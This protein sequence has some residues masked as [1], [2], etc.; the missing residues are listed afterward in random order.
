MLHA[1]VQNCE[2]QTGMSRRQAFARRLCLLLIVWAPPTTKTAFRTLS[3][4]PVP[5]IFQEAET[6]E[7][8]V[9]AVFNAYVSV[10]R[11]AGTNRPTNIVWPKVLFPPW[12]IWWRPWWLFVVW[13]NCWYLSRQSHGGQDSLAVCTHAFLSRLFLPL[14]LPRAAGCPFMRIV[15]TS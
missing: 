4:Q 7:Q 15:C 14:S 8:K 10:Q 3:E 13:G 11:D 1:L 2:L 12:Q 6:F 5:Y 9:A